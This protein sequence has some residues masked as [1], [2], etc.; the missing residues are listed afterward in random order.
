MEDL[1]VV[2]TVFEIV[3]LWR[4]S[5]PI[6][7]ELAASRAQYGGIRQEHGRSV[8]AAIDLLGG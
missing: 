2:M 8:I 7:V 5:G 4:K 6:H 1:R 3:R